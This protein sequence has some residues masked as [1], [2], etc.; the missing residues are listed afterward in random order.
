MQKILTTCVCVCVASL[1]TVSNCV[2]FS[3]VHFVENV[4]CDAA[5]SEIVAVAFKVVPFVF[6]S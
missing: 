6:Y 3:A 1:H 4:H 5:N 2:C